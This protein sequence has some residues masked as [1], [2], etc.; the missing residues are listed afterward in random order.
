MSKRIHIGTSGWNYKHWLGTFYPE[1]IKA[2]NQLGY[3]ASFLDA[4]EIN[5]SFYA[6]PTPERLAKWRLSTPKNFLFSVKA[7]RYI[8]HIKK[9]KGGGAITESFFSSVAMLKEKLG[10]ILIQLPP[11]FEMDYPRLELFLKEVPRRF[12]YVF[13]FRNETWHDDK[14]LALLKKFNCAYCIYELA[15]QPSPKEVTT[16]FVYV[17]LH[18]PEDKY[19]GNYPNEMLEHWADECR[20]WLARGKDVFVYFDND[21]HAFAVQ[22]AIALKRLL[23]QRVEESQHELSMVH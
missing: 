8:S 15:G 10:P 16:D 12:R 13:E 20:A 1:D 21:Q 19:T 9:L 17:R 23:G 2:S 5:N 18:C 14:I 6:L 3:Y 7:S 22:N 4:V 11:G